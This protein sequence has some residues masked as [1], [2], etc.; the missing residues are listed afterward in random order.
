MNAQISASEISRIKDTNKISDVIG[1]HVRW[2]KRKSRF[3][4]GDYWA[5]CP[6][7]GES[8]PSFHCDD[9][10]GFYHCFGCGASGDA[11]KFLQEYVGLNFAQA[12]QELGGD[13][14]TPISP[15]RE[16]ELREKREGDMARLQAEQEMSEE[17]R[18]RVAR[19]TFK[20]GIPI[21]GTPAETYLLGRGIPKQ[22]WE[23]DRLR[24]FEAIDLDCPP[25]GKSPALVSAATNVDDEITAIWRIY[26]DHEGNALRDDNGDKIKMGKG[27][28]A[29]SAVRLGPAA[30]TIAVT[31]GLETA[32]GVK[33]LTGGKFC[34]WA[35]LST[36]GMTGLDIPKIVKEIR[37]YADGDFARFHKEKHH[38]IPPPGLQAAWEL[39]R[40]AVERNIKVIIEEPPQGSDW[41][42]VW[43]NVSGC[44]V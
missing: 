30:S 14:S 18:A 26:L 43:Q 23:L 25:F 7:H 22:E 12:I 10:K 5:C 33:A 35:G 11:I 9:K 44:D 27:P 3:A 29:G 28:A 41:L 17:Q 42:D 13:V 24:Y 16:R 6:F 34:V 37:I 38:L 1:A 31:E 32:F 20:L 21:E 8:T 15:Q 40:R 2:D 4:I 39:E 36:S 19:A